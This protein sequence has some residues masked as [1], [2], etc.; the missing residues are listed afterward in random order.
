MSHYTHVPYVNYLTRYKLLSAPDQ[1]HLIHPTHQSPLKFS[2]MSPLYP[3]Q[4]WKKKIPL[5][6][7]INKSIRKKHNSAYPNSE[8]IHH[9]SGYVHPEFRIG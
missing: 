6:F 3:W 4:C 5:S 9:H 7:R 2:Y 8:H 1:H